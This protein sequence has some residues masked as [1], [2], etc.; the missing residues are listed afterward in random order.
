MREVRE[1]Y[2]RQPQPAPHQAH[3]LT[4]TPS[5]PRGAVTSPAPQPTDTTRGAPLLSP[6]TL[7]NIRPSSHIYE[8]YTGEPNK[9]L[10]KHPPPTPPSNPR[11]DLMDTHHPKGAPHKRAHP[12]PT[13]PPATS[14]PAPL[15]T[16]T[17]PPVHRHSQQPPRFSWFLPTPAAVRCPHMPSSTNPPPTR[18]P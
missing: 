6:R 10:T 7:K 1:T 2:T 5:T 12:K 11:L 17:R 4:S 8:V 9:S 3:D 14:Y 13:P 18:R 15:T 16:A